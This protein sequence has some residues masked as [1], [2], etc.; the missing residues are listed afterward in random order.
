MTDATIVCEISAAQLKGLLMTAGK[1][2]VRYYLNGIY[3][4]TVCGRLV[5]TDGHCAV[6]MRHTLDAGTEPFILSRCIAERALKLATRKFPTLTV[7]ISAGPERRT[8]ILRHA[9]GAVTGLEI[10]GRFPQY[11]LIVPQEVSGVTGNFN[12]QLLAAVDK[13]IT[14]CAYEEPKEQA[15]ILHHNGSDKAAVMTCSNPG[16]LG[17]IMPMRVDQRGIGQFTEALAELGLAPEPKTEGA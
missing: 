12:P 16:V 9:N 10:E 5:S 8:I 17:V 14:L 11:Q 2:D 6:L 4:D 7:G 1:S 15:T 13:A 3:F